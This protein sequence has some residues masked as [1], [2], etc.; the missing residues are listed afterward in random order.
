M[1]AVTSEM[2]HGGNGEA[3]GH[4]QGGSS[5]P[6]LGPSGTTCTRK[7]GRGEADG[8]DQQTTEALTLGVVSVR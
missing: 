3:P 8:L 7:A 5:Q 4:E 2:T 1:L 6:R